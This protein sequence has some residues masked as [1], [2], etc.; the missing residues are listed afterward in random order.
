MST[1]LCLYMSRSAKEGDV[2]DFVC[3]ANLL[4]AMVP[5]LCCLRLSVDTAVGSRLSCCW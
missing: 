5:E 3:T 2:S 1:L 4:S